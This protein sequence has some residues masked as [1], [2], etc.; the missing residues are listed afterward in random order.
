MGV[1]TMSNERVTRATLILF[2]GTGDLAARKLLPALFNVWSQG[3]LQDCLIVGIGRRAKNTEEYLAFLNE[4]VDVAQSQPSDWANF[5][6]NIDYHHGEIQTLEDFK[7]LRFRLDELEKQRNLPGHRLFYYAVGP[8]WFA[9]I[10]RRLG[11]SGLLVKKEAAPGEP[12]TR[13]VVEKPFGHDLASARAL[14]AELQHLADESQIFRIDHYLGKETVQNVL[15][16]RFANGLFEPIWNHHYIDHVQITVAESLGVGSRAGYYEE[17]GAMRDMVQNH[18]LHLLS[19]TAMEPPISMEPNAIRDEKVKALRAIRVP[20]NIEQVDCCTVRGQ[21]G[22]GT[23][24]GAEVPSYRDEQ[25]VAPD[26]TTPTFVAA[27][28][29]LDTWRWANVPFLLRHGKRLAKRGTEIAIQFKTPP[30][31]LFRGLEITG[32]P[33]SQLILR[34]QPNEG[35]T[36]NFGAK[37]PGSGMQITSVGMTFD[38][39]ATFHHKVA[40][41]YERLL[42]DALLGDPTLF[43]RSDEVAAMWRW[44]DAILSAWDKLPAPDFPNYRAGSWGPS[45]AESLFPQAGEIAAN[46]CPVSWRRW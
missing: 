4:K 38:Y 31:A 37:R 39:E 21:Y 23:I 19:M 42:L 36:L 27:R 40:D 30:L 11:E 44:A 15:A 2:G 18:M 28:L 10:T 1:N 43:T 7:S 5:A 9:P 17:S 34:I 26:S 35:I 8:E 25:G 22:A 46:T 41:S 32:R 20:S 14:D 24:D 6:R 45:D 16:L 13:I 12:W 3:R 29:F 33:A